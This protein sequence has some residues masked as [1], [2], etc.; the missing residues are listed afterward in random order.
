MKAIDRAARWSEDLEQ[1]GFE[2]ECQTEAYRDG[3]YLRVEA[4]RG[5]IQIRFTLRMNT[6]FTRFVTGSVRSGGWRS[7][8]QQ[9]SKMSDAIY[10]EIEWVRYLDRQVTA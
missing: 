9:P 2:I 10:R 3:E 4:F 8:T 6:K 1:A 7:R 5:Y